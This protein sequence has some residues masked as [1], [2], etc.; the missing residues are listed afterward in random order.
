M[1][2]SAAGS[3]AA[4]GVL[5]TMGAVSLARNS[6]KPHGRL[7]AIPLLFGL[8]QMAEGAVWLTIGTTAHRLLHHVAVN[9][10]LTFALIVWP[11]WMPW[12][13]KGIE[14]DA[15]RRRLLSALAW[16]GRLVSLYAVVLLVR[17]SPSAHVA[18]HSITY[19]YLPAG[20]VHITH[21][22]YPLA[23]GLTAIAPFFVSTARLARWGGLAL[24]GSLT[25]AATVE[26]A[27]LTSVWCFFAAL[28]SGLFIVMVH[29]DSRRLNDLEGPIHVHAPA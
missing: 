2:F 17:W 13:L 5:T 21:F 20:Q 14:Q 25:A 16:A 4:S 19:D 29:R 7:A 3:F 23:Y 26:L 11:T 27:A 28:L 8:Q 24:V 15:A 1:C 6:S 9:A 12:A 22:A 18:G 10:F